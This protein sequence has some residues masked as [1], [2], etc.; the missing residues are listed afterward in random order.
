[1][2]DFYKSSSMIPLVGGFVCYEYFHHI[3]VYIGH[4]SLT[5]YKELGLLYNSIKNLFLDK[6]NLEL[7][8]IVYYEIK[9]LDE[10]EAENT[11]ADPIFKIVRKDADT[12]TR[13]QEVL[14]AMVLVESL[15]EINK[16]NL[17]FESTPDLDLLLAIVRLQY[18]SPYDMTK[19]LTAFFDSE[20][21][22]CF[23]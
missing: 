15:N 1:M 8:D 5:S 4:D 19:I 9:F 22:K 6:K 10:Y 18:T 14:A 20:F 13:H 16:K 21:E 11:K 17:N 7:P 2:L 3:H 23:L 12:I